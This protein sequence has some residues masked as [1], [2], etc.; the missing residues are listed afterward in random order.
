M[1]NCIHNS[2]TLT[3][4]DVPSG[5][6]APSEEMT[7]FRVPLVCE[8]ASGLGCGTIAAPVL[9]DLECQPAV[10]SAWLNRDG[11]VLGI[12]WTDGARDPEPVLSTLQRH[13][14]AGVELKGPDHQRNCDSFAAEAWYRPVQ[15]Q[16]LSAEEARV[17]AARL[18]R[19]L[20]QNVR[21]P[22]GTA[23]RLA[24]SLGDACARALAGASPTSASAR[25][26]Q[27]AAALLD[28]GRDVLE[29]S[30][31]QAFAAAVSLGH[32]PLPGEA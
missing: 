26:E 32:R 23:E 8:A 21:V 17:I 30:A 11:T 16:D 24:R 29:P 7:F 22:A 6:D 20:E 10:A 2:E 19:R 18:V 14:V 15:L 31:F 27:I 4:M 28:A 5:Q 13:G 25:R 1:K 3:P 9:A 12:V